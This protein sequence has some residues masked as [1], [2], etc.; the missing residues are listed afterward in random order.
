MSTVMDNDDMHNAEYIVRIVYLIIG[1]GLDVMMEIVIFMHIG[2]LISATKNAEK[3]AQL[4]R[5]QVV[6]VEPGT[7][8]LPSAYQLI[9]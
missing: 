3:L 5:K 4:K 1:L 6:M 7:L 9:E 2:G 8:P